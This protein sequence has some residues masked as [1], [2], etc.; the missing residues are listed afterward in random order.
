MGAK[1][2]SWDRVNKIYSAI[3]HFFM[4]WKKLFLTIFIIVVPLVSALIIKDSKFQMFPKFDSTNIKVTFK[5]NENSTLEESFAIVKS[6]EKDLIGKK[7]KFSIYH[8]DSVAG[9]RYDSGNNKENAANAMYMTIELG[10]LRADN[11]IDTYI[12]PYLSFYSNDVNKT[13]TDNSK[14][15][16]KMLKKFFDKKDYKEKF[17]LQE[18]AVLEKKVGPIKADIKIGIAS[19]D[20]QKIIAAISALSEEL[21]GYDGV[22]NIANSLKFG[23]DEIKIRV[24]NYGQRLGLNERT[25]GTYLSSLYLSKKATVVF[26]D[27]GM[28]DIKIK[29]I[30][31][32]SFDSFKDR[33]IPLSDGTRVALGDVCELDITQ[34]LAQLVKDNGAINFYIYANV[35]PEIVT[36]SEVI[37]KLNPALEKVKKTGVKL[38]FKGEAEKNKELQRDMLLATSLAFVLIML[39]ILYLFNSFQE[40]FILMSVIPFS[41]LGALLGHEVMGMN[42]S[43]PSMIGALGLAGVV[44][45]DGIIMMTYLKKAQNLEEIFVRAG[46]RFRPIILTTLTTLLGM[47]S[48][49]FFPTGEA[50]MFQPIAVALGFGLLWGTILNLIYLPVLYTLVKGIK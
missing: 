25:I 40:T 35:D 13:R 49:I 30:D 17:D 50:A 3:I 5:A 48:L 28:V 47:S 38:V 8:I 9:Y 29:S 26:D 23:I 31:K 10:P 27:T 46:K 37:S 44:I 22:K 33:L 7:D 21:K 19:E 16:A 43:M 32:D 15:I 2:T 12:T 34:T 24:T 36:S 42:I 4:R 1:V 39:S 41:V 11:P 45:N 18:L 6:I 14:K 20:T